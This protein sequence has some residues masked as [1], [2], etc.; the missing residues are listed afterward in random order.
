MDSGING[1]VVTAAEAVTRTVCS[2]GV[3]TGFYSAW[4]RKFKKL[5]AWRPFFLL[6]F[7]VVLCGVVA[8][9]DVY[10]TMSNT[11]IIK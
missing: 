2:S 10:A 11:S 9:V 6:S 1:S 5:V 8:T 4:N 3:T 7:R